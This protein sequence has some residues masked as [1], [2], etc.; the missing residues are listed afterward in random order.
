MGGSVVDDVL[1]LALPPPVGSPL[2]L[3]GLQM[4]ELINT[5]VEQNISHEML[6]STVIKVFST[7]INSWNMS[8]LQAAQ[9]AADVSGV[10]A[11]TA[12]K[13]VATYYLSLIGV[14]LHNVDGA[15]SK[16]AA[17]SCSGVY[18]RGLRGLEHPPQ[19]GLSTSVYYTSISLL[20]TLI[21]DDLHIQ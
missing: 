12:R 7:A 15:D 4:R 3:Q 21:F 10:T 5:Y 8:I 17:G 2:G 16:E 1:H 13:W 9:C 20:L 14:N 18:R 19:P 6:K 11:Y